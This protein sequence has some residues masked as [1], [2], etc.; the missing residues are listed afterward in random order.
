MSFIFF[1]GLFGGHPFILL[2]LC[3]NIDKQHQTKYQRVRG[4]AMYKIYESSEYLNRIEAANYLGM[5]ES[6]LRFWACRQP[7][8]LPFIK[9]GHRVKYRKEALDKFLKEITVFVG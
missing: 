7:S 1:T 2:L 6:T 8:K 4:N 3:A 5:K 9:I